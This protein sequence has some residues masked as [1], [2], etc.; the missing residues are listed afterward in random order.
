[1]KWSEIF[2]SGSSPLWVTGTGYLQNDVVRSPIDW[3]LYVRITNGAGTTDPSADTTNYKP[4]GARLKKPRVAGVIAIAN[5]A[6]SATATIAAVDVTKA[7][8]V[9]LG[10][11]YG[12]TEIAAGLVR[13]TLTNATTI[14]ATRGGATGG[15]QTGYELRETL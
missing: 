8:L 10:T 9:C 4:A 6:T 12:N 7:E 5:G 11:E 2:G 13:L 15:S 14:T 3:Q 1:M